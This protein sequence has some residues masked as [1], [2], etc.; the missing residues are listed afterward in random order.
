MLNNNENF[1]DE[2]YDNLHESEKKLF[3]EE[4]EDFR[5]NICTEEHKYINTSGLFKLLEAH[6][7]ISGQ[8]RKEVIQ[9][10]FNKGYINKDDSNNHALQINLNMLGNCLQEKDGDYDKLYNIVKDVY[11]TPMIQQ[12]KNSDP[13]KEEIINNFRND[14]YDYY[15]IDE[16][17]WNIK[18][19]KK[20]GADDVEAR[21]VLYKK[22]RRNVKES[23]CP[24]WIIDVIK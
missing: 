9:F 17:E 13:V 4:Y 14:I 19:T 21:E 7:K 16:V 12:L 1:A 3:E 15:D 22:Y 11:D 2:F 10:E 24:A 5:H 18:M 6:E 23:S 8:I 20:P